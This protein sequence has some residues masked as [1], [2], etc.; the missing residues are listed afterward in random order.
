MEEDG[1]GGGQAAR[2]QEEAGGD[3]CGGIR[4]Y[5][6]VSKYYSTRLKAPSRVLFPSVDTDGQ[7]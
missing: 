7:T 1:G 2:G 5:Q 3:H 4:H 6:S